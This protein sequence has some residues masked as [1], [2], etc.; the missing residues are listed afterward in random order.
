MDSHGL[1]LF[2]LQ[3]AFAPEKPPFSYAYEALVKKKK[4]MFCSTILLVPRFDLEME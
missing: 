3:K 2:I 1:H 4:I